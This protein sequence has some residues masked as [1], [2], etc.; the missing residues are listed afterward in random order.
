MKLLKACF[1]NKAQDLTIGGINV[2]A[3]PEV[4]SHNVHIMDGWRSVYWTELA[5][6]NPVIGS[7]GHVLTYSWTFF[8]VYYVKK[9]TNFKSKPFQK[10][11]LP[12]SSDESIEPNLFTVD[13]LTKLYAFTSRRK[14]SH[15]QKYYVFL[16][17]LFS[18]S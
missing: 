3:N 1:H 7:C 16:K 14:Q 13:H 6:G 4:C 10:L 15:V 8:F 2:A 5:L 9:Y 11:A 18:L 12:S 17:F